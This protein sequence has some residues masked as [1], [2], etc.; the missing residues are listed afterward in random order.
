MI[1]S[2]LSLVF[3]VSVTDYHGEAS[4]GLGSVVLGAVKIQGYR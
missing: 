1:A 4:Y 3:H 2:L